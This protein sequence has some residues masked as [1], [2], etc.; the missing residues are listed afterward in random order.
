[1]ATLDRVTE[2][3]GLGGACPQPP[4][5][6]GELQILP[7][8]GAHPETTTWH[9]PHLH[10][11]PAMPEGVFQDSWGQHRRTRATSQHLAVASLHLIPGNKAPS[12]PGVCSLFGCG[13]LGAL[14][15]AV[16]EHPQP[17]PGPPGR[18]PG[19]RC[20]ESQPW[21]Q[22]G[23]GGLCERELSTPSPGLSGG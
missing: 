19:V 8:L 11:P 13:L 12:Y 5:S 15:T 10:R 7:P 1:M 4:S 9:G 18:K 3:E 6:L 16:F 2:E 23:H 14:T 17:L 20:G 21:L 22:D